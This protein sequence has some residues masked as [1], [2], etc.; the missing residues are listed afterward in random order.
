[1]KFNAVEYF[2]CLYKEEQNGRWLALSQIET[3]AGKMDEL[4]Y[5]IRLNVK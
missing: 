3:R 1:M 4:Y 5:E 2:A